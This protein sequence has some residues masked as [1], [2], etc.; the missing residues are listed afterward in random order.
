[1]DNNSSAVS[2]LLKEIN[3]LKDKVRELEKYI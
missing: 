1:M 2:I 3:E